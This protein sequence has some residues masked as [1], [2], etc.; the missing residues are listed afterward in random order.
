M[1]FQEQ[2][3]DNFVFIE[4]TLLLTTLVSV[5]SIKFLVQVSWWQCPHTNYVWQIWLTTFST[6]T[7]MERKVWFWKCFCHDHL[8]EII[9]AYLPDTA[10]LFTFFLCWI[11]IGIT[12]KPF[13]D[14]CLL[15]PLQRVGFSQ[16]KLKSCYM[17]NLQILQNKYS[18]KLTSNQS[19]LQ[20]VEKPFLRNNAFCTWHL[21]KNCPVTFDIILLL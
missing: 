6:V 8:R 13:I 21:T 11:L 1:L 3:T 20:L 9:F 2:L 16:F 7:I 14:T 5:K 4:L 18:L 17:N 15:S 10:K 19:F 12:I